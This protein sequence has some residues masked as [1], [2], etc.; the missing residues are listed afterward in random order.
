MFSP[1]YWDEKAVGNRHFFFLLDG[2]K[3][4]GTA[5]GF[6]NEFLSAELDQHRKV[7]EMVGAKMQTEES[8]HQLSGIGFS[9]TQRN[10]IL[11]RV[12]G[13]FTRTIKIIF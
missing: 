6:Y 3:N 11:V 7:L 2:C 1:N 8:D 10:D 12:K 9:S 13:T 4:D 5:R